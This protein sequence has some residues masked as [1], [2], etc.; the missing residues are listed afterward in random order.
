MLPMKKMIM[1]TQ[2]KNCTV[3]EVVPNASSPFACQLGQ[4]KW[5]EEEQIS[6]ATENGKEHKGSNLPEKQVCCLFLL[7]LYIHSLSHVLISF[8]FNFTGFRSST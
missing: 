2:C 3:E 5:C 8:F 6:N 4:R 1:L 7:K